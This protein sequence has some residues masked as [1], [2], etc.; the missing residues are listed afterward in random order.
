MARR[1]GLWVDDVWEGAGT[2]VALVGL[3]V[4]IG[5]AVG[6]A[7]QRWAADP[8]FVVWHG[9]PTGAVSKAASDLGYKVERDYL[10]DRAREQATVERLLTLPVGSQILWENPETGNRGVVWV[11]GD[12]AADAAEPAGTF[13]R[14]LVRH[15]LLNNAYRNSL[16]TTCHAPGQPYS[17]DVAWRIE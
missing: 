11:A 3:A 14:D 12:H 16:G 4:L 6:F 10:A 8:A 9:G 7:A 1:E 17:P 15:T 5:L 2:I 13:C